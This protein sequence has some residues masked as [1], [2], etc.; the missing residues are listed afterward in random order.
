MDWGYLSEF[1]DKIAVVG[2][3][4]VEWFQGIGNAVAGAIGALFEDLIHHIYDVFYIAQYLI[5]NLVELFEVVFI[6]LIWV[7]NLIKG[8]FISAFADPV[9]PGIDWVFSDEIL[10]VFQVIPYW[11]IFTFALGAGISIIV[12]VFILKR[13]TAI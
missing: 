4:T 8:F 7:F 13:L 10:S 12:L 1:W 3:Y 2:E 6:P 11:D 5:D 9:E